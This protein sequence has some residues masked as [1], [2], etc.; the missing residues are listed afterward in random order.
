MESSSTL[1]SHTLTLIPFTLHSF[2][3]FLPANFSRAKCKSDS[4]V[5]KVFIPLTLSHLRN[6]HLLVVL[7]DRLERLAGRAFKRHSKRRHEESS[8]HQKA[9]EE[10]EEVEEATHEEEGGE[11]KALWEIDEADAPYISLEG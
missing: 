6:R 5:W 11:A 7:M 1:I 3:H 2:K 4:R 8:S 9:P 10:V